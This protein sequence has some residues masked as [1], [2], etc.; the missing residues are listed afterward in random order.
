MKEVVLLVLHRVRQG[1]LRDYSS[2]C[3]SPAL[4]SSASFVAEQEAPAWLDGATQVTYLA[5][6]FVGR[7]SFHLE[8]SKVPL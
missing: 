1:G 5:E 3:R 2:Q 6:G 4:A 7:F 8:C